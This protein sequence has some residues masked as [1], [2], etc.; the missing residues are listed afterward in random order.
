MKRRHL[1]FTLIELLV[2]IAI[3]GVLIAM[4]LP[5]AQQVRQAALKLECGNNL[6]QQGLALHAYHDV[7]GCFPP[8]KIN[9]GVEYTD[10]GP[11]YLGHADY[12]GTGT[13]RVYNH[14][15]FTL[16]LPYLEMDGLYRQY[17]MDYPACNARYRNSIDVDVGGFTFA[18]LANG[19]MDACPGDA[20]ALVVGSYV[21]AYHC[22]ADDEPFAETVTIRGSV[23]ICRDAMR[24]NYGFC[25]Y[26]SPWEMFGVTRSGI[27]YWFLDLY[28]GLDLRPGMFANNSRTRLLDIADGASNTIAIAEMK[29][30]AV[31]H[32]A[33]GEQS[34]NG[35]PYLLSPHWGAGHEASVSICMKRWENVPAYTSHINYQARSELEIINEHSPYY[36]LQYTMGAGSYHNGGANVLLADGSVQFLRNHMSFAVYQSMGTI[37]AGEEVPVNID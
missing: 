3:I 22:P 14:T 5:A 33:G 12:Y 34:Y 17:N 18:S 21:K 4:L 28:V 37:N 19:G 15:G 36:G 7:Y 9:S 27:V 8:S 13:Y 30:R 31:G 10:D 29:Q 16:L 32:V 1:G 20:N 35:D 2:V 25:V 24:S 23:L 26:S 11:T 6:K